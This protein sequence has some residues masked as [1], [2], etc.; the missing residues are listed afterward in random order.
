[1]AGF[2]KGKP[3]GAKR[4]A[5]GKGDRTGST[6]GRKPIGKVNSQV[7]LKRT[8][9]KVRQMTYAKATGSEKDRLLNL[10]IAELGGIPAKAQKMPYKNRIGLAKAKKERRHQAHV[11]AIATGSYYTIKDKE[12]GKTKK[13][14]LLTDTH[15]R[16]AKYNIEDKTKHLAQKAKRKARTNAVYTREETGEH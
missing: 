16:V 5:K 7:D 15:S 14:P 2:A 3:Q 8:L 11:E 4:D 1:M 9:A 10:R 13:I 12:T 6:S